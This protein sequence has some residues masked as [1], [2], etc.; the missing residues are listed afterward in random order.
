MGGYR[1]KKTTEQFINEAKIIHGD[2]YDYSKVKYVNNRTKVCIICKKHGEFWQ[3]A[4][5]H[6]KGYGCNKCWTE[7]KKKKH[8][9]A[10]VG[11]NDYEGKVAINGKEIKSYQAWRNMISRCYCNNTRNRYK[12]YEDCEVSDEWKYFSNFKKWFDEHHIEGYDLDKDLL[13]PNNRIYSAETCI[14]VPHRLNTLFRELGRAKEC[15]MAG[16]S[17][18]KKPNHNKYRVVFRSNGKSKCLYGFK[19]EIEAHNSYVKSKIE[20]VRRVANEFYDNGD[21]DDKVYNAVVT[22]FKG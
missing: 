13:I 19:T 5:G 20:E 7:E 9:V 14:F 11:I 17:F 4:G 18:D 8:L 1:V 6:L 2:K 10:G 16:V 12:T 22:Y 3:E 21:I 15:S